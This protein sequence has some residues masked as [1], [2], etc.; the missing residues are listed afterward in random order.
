M[1]APTIESFVRPP[2]FI[3][4]DPSLPR[5]GDCGI[6]VDE[7]ALKTKEVFSSRLNFGMFAFVSTML[8]PN[9]PKL[10]RRFVRHGE[11]RQKLSKTAICVDRESAREQ[12]KEAQFQQRLNHLCQQAEDTWWFPNATANSIS[13]KAP[14]F[15]S[16]SWTGEPRPPKESFELVAPELEESTIKSLYEYGFHPYW[17]GLQPFTIGGPI[18]DYEKEQRELEQKEQR[19]RKLLIV[20]NSSKSRMSTVMSNAVFDVLIGGTKLGQA[21]SSRGLK[22]RSLSMTI[23]RVTDRLQ[24]LPKTA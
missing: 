16:P 12:I 5:I 13:G 14:V 20:L 24:D 6:G 11:F 7:T 23:M 22:P 3:P 10:L 4:C 17:L 1:T 18:S 21:A 9:A 2:V 15:Y 8:V 19:K